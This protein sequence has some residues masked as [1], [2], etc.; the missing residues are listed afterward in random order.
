MAV[1]SACNPIYE[2]WPGWKRSTTGITA[3]RALPVEARRYLA[4]L[5]ELAGCPIDLVSSGSKREQTIVL[6]NPLLRSRRRSG[7]RPQACAWLFL[8]RFLYSVLECGSA[9][10]RR[11]LVSR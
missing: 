9:S 8:E 3:Y 10:R 5:E 4:R 2:T 11:R 1:L 7:A 6:R